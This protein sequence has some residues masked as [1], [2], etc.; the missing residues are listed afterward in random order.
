[1]ADEERVVVRDAA[2]AQQCERS[3]G[4]TVDSQLQELASQFRPQSLRRAESDDPTGM[5]DGEPVAEPLCL[6][7][8]VR[9]HEDRQLISTLET[10]DQIQQFVPDSRIQADSRLVEEEDARA[11]NESA[12]QL[13]TSALAAA[14][15]GDR[16]V[17]ER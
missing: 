5:D 13:E 9:R 8:V 7:E 2:R 16:A 14:V 6:V 15:G 11:R 12:R 17:D 10:R 4:V 3:G 1:R